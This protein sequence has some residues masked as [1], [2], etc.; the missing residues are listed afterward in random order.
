MEGLYAVGGV[1]PIEKIST[2]FMFIYMLCNCTY[3]VIDEYC[4]CMLYMLDA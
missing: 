1:T 2:S 4:L 3:V